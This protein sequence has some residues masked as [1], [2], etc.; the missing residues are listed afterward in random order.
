MFSFNSSKAY[1][2]FNKL[3]KFCKQHWFRKCLKIQLNYI[4]INMEGTTKIRLFKSFPLL[5]VL[6]PYYGTADLS[7]LLLSALSADSRATL[8]KNY[9][10]F[11]KVMENSKKFVDINSNWIDLIKLPSDLFIINI[12]LEN[13]RSV[14]EFISFIRSIKERSGCYFQDHFMHEILSINKIKVSRDLVLILIQE[15]AMRSVY[16]QSKEYSPIYD[17]FNSSLSVLEVVT[18]NVLY[19]LNIFSKSII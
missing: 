15:E 12:A 8:H 16:T 17:D 13:H 1:K 6:M 3:A 14:S 18:F 7:F 9:C 10:E 4:K 5:S 2:C 19:F 11:K